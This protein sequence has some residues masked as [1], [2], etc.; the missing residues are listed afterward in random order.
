MAVVPWFN[1]TGPQGLVQQPMG[2]SY[3]RLAF[4]LK[5]AQERLHRTQ[6]LQAQRHAAQGARDDISR[7]R[8]A[9]IAAKDQSRVGGLPSGPMPDADVTGTV[10]PMNSQAPKPVKFPPG[11]KA[12]AETPFVA[13]APETDGRKRLTEA[14]IQ[15]AYKRNPQQLSDPAPP[16]NMIASAPKPAARPSRPHEGLAKALAAPAR[17]TPAETAV[18]RAAAPPQTPRPQA[19]PARRA[20]QEP[21]QDG[22][23]LAT[24]IRMAAGELGIDPVDLGAAISY[25]TAGTFNP[26]IKG[27]TTKWG[28]HKGLIQWGEPQAQKYLGGD[29]SIPSQAK[30]IVAYL[31]DAG[32]KA[33]HGLKDIYSAINAGRVGRYGASDA[34]V[35]GAPGTVADK[36]NNQMAGHRRKALA[37]LG[38]EM[39][40]PTGEDWMTGG[41]TM[42]AAAPS[43]EPSPVMAFA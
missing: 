16:P 12:G 1:K 27:P 36:V 42:M 5:E 3:G 21:A 2:E 43:S 6:G 39:S 25:E 17:A 23:E 34:H 37:L 28:R 19:Q 14:L 31:R 35:G 30:G 13:R 20:P 29:F 38:G 7:L 40:E 22:G 18:T 11:V 4:A 8:E 24:A 33:G 32:V 9:M 15:Q 26:T 10:V 41:E